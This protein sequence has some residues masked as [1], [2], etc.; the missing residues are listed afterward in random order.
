MRESLP[1]FDRLFDYYSYFLHGVLQEYPFFCSFLPPGLAGASKSGPFF[2]RQNLPVP[3]KFLLDSGSFSGAFLGGTPAEEV[4]II[5]EI[6][7]STASY[8]H[9]PQSFPQSFFF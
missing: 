2:I 9:Y 4:Y 5:L 8:K 6:I 7:S 3:L 1:L